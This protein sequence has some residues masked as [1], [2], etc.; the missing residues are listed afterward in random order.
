MKLVCQSVI[1]LTST[2]EPYQQKQ[3]RFNLFII[4]HTQHRKFSYF[5]QPA[6]RKHLNFIYIH[7]INTQLTTLK[8]IYSRLGTEE[9]DL[10]TK[11]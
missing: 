5:L 6:R 9:F 4:L 8:S 10:E 7:L 1:K 11:F 2:F 3:R